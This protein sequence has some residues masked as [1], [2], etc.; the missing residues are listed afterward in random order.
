MKVAVI[1]A[2][3]SSRSQDMA[4][5]LDLGLRKANEL[6]YG[7]DQ[8]RVIED[9]GVSARQVPLSHRRGLNEVLAMIRRGEVAIL[10]VYDR[11]RLARETQEYLRLL[12]L[13]AKH[14][15]S[16]VY[17]ARGASPFTTRIVQ[18]AQL[19]L[20]SQMEGNRI[21]QRTQDARC[22]YP[23]CLY[24]FRRVGKGVEAHYV[25]DE[26]QY[27]YLVSLFTDFST[28][29]DAED[30]TAFRK[31]W[32]KTIKRDVAVLLQNPFYAAALIGED[33]TTETLRHIE[34]MV[35]LSTILQNRHTLAVW[36]I[37][38]AQRAPTPTTWMLDASI[39][40]SCG[41]CGRAMTIRLQKGVE[42]YRCRCKVATR[43]AT[44]AVEAAVS[45]ALS[46][47]VER[48]QWSRLQEVTREEIAALR[49]SEE[50]RKSQLEIQRQ[51]LC[52]QIVSQLDS[53]I[54]KDVLSRYQAMKLEI[55]E[56][57]ER[58]AHLATLWLDTQDVV[59]QALSTLRRQA[60]DSPLALAPL[61]I[62]SLT[63]TAETI[64]V[65]HYGAAF[66]DA[67][68]AV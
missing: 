19:A 51:T 61:L 18:E 54:R 2:R 28:V 53:P 60:A 41:S 23:S 36:G 63:I 52:E 14:G 6:G 27:E 9:Y 55:G 8:I 22:Y 66:L 21:A 35:P 38:V 1:Y 57:N 34:P 32:K 42:Y 47:L 64:V 45:T 58:L 16:V 62:H 17:T 12:S 50:R 56:V 67:A 44:A 20:N 68:N 4:V 10:I 33:G 11:D 49:Q 7:V 26:A 46:E 43:A 31:K 40:V 30:F 13:L 24:G 25:V 59:Q 29:T 3:V 5:Q 15:V 37:T 65:T 39:P 48:M